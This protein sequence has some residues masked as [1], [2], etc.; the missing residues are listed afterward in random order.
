[1]GF[2]EDPMAS[3]SNGGPGTWMCPDAWIGGSNQVFTLPESVY[4]ET[5]A[6]AERMLGWFDR[7]DGLRSV[8]LRYFNAAGA[9]AD[10][11]IGEDWAF[12]INLVPVVMYGGPEGVS[13]RDGKLCDLAPSLL[14]L[15]G[16]EQPEEM[17]G[18]SLIVH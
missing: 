14:E 9:S 10:A 3:G 5:K 8:S 16:L 2:H 17:T 1:M 15:M 18:E 12:S 11:L 6:V 7:T 13:L 4:A